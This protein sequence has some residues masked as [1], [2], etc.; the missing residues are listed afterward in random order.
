M[1]LGTDVVAIDGGWYHTCAVVADGTLKC[2]GWNSHGQLSNGTTIDSYT[3][4][5]ALSVP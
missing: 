2:W 4:V 1:G 3:A 5:D